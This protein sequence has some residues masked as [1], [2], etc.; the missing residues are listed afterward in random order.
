MDEFLDKLP[1]FAAGAAAT[2]G[3]LFTNFKDADSKTKAMYIFGFIIAL[4]IVLAVIG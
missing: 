2:I 4:A 3:A 1:E